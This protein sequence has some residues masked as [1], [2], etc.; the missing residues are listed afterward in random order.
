L[1]LLAQGVRFIDPV[2]AE[3]RNFRSRI[4]LDW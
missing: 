2:S 1:K 3:E 4:T